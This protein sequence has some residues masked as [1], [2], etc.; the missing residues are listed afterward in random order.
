MVEKKEGVLIRDICRII[1]ELVF[2]RVSGSFDS[3]YYLRHYTDVR[4]SKLNSLLHY[5]V[6]G[7]KEGRNPSGAFNTEEYLKANPDVYSNPLYHYL[8]FGIKE[9]RQ[10]NDYIGTLENQL[11]KVEV[12]LTKVKAQL[13]VTELAYEEYSAPIGEEEH[14]QRLSTYKE[15]KAPKR[16]AFYTAITGG[17]EE[18]KVPEFFDEEFEYYIFTDDANLVVKEP[19]VKVVLDKFEVDP[20]RLARWVKL[21][22]FKLLGSYECAIWVDSCFLVKN[23]LLPYVRKVELGTA[24][25]GMYPH[26]ERVSFIEEAEACRNLLKDNDTEILRQLEWYKNHD[27]LDEICRAPLIETGVFV[28]NL[29]S[30]GT[31]DLFS[32]WH[33]EVFRRS[34]RDQLSISYAIS[35]VKPKMLML[36]VSRILIPRFNRLIYEIYKHS[37]DTPYKQ[38]NYISNVVSISLDEYLHSAAV[39]CNTVTLS[40]VV[41]VYNAEKVLAELLV[42][43]GRQTDSDFELILVNDGSDAPATQLINK[44]RH[45]D[46]IVIENDINIGYTRTV[47]KG[48]AVAQGELIVVL[49]SDTVLPTSFVKD[50]K[51]FSTDHPYIDA[52]GPISNAASWQS[53]P[54]I[55]DPDTGRLAVNALPE[56]WGVDEVSTYIKA[57]KIGSKYIPVNLLNGF[58][59]VVRKNVYREA[60]M[61]DHDKFPRGYG[62]EDDFFIRLNLSG[63]LIAIVPNIY[64]FHHKTQSF[65]AEQK[66][67]NSQAGQKVLHE[68][69]SKELI[70]RLVKNSSSNPKLVALRDRIRSEIY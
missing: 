49:N 8:R 54:E 6:H 55:V 32:L 31:R 17:Y 63:K 68:L 27:G 70:Q 46:V 57:V 62:E 51:Q 11:S 50:I 58:C 67:D 18:L 9:G 36:E 41:P 25:I 39:Q 38:A 16:Y 69:Y 20:T 44:C 35:Q 42:S 28:A 52:F 59:Y 56:G 37:S 33:A 66:S 21:S 5:I 10:L 65:T 1:K 22:P 15:S 24:D 45:S 13:S 30:E 29:R 48:V 43:I 26:P 3:D 2:I 40:I 61:L 19:F 64:V 14:L 47:N 12:Q 7:W 60:G 34:R 53:V 23:S 4:S